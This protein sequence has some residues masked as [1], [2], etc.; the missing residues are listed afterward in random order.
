VA[1]A[2]YYLPGVHA[3]TLLQA[4]LCGALLALAY[5]LLRPVA[6]ILTGVFNLMT[7]GLMGWI[8]DAALVMACANRIDGFRVDGF[9]WAALVA[10]AVNVL[11][12]VFDLFGKKQP[13]RVKEKE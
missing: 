11:R 13:R 5:V 7:L 2:A 3:D 1:A 6:R 4:V 9:Q 8:I 10:L 12:W